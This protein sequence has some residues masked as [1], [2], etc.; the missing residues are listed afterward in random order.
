MSKTGQTYDTFASTSDST[1]AHP[2][3]E[4]SR[5][6]ETTSLLNAHN[7]QDAS[8]DGEPKSFLRKNVGL[9]MI[10]GSGIFSCLM[11]VVVKKLNEIDPP[12]PTLEVSQ[13]T[14]VTSLTNQCLS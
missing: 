6:E 2:T 12:V 14:W 7:A 9:F 10:M 13:T 11:N 1:K 3:P 4:S 5:A 8:A